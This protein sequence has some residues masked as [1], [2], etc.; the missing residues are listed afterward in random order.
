MATRSSNFLNTSVSLAENGAWVGVGANS[1]LVGPPM[2]LEFA[3]ADDAK[4]QHLERGVR[5]ALVLA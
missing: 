5:R 4:N 2:V 3:I 1:A